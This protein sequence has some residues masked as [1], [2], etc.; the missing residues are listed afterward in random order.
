MLLSHSGSEKDLQEAFKLFNESSA[1]GNPDGYYNKGILLRQGQGVAKDPVAAQVAL[2]AAA[3]LG[4]PS[5][6]IMLAEMLIIGEGGPDDYVRAILLLKLISG[7]TRCAERWRLLLSREM[8]STRFTT[9]MCL[10]F[11]TVSHRNGQNWSRSQRWH[12]VLCRQQ[13]DR[14]H[15]LAHTFGFSGL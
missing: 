14:G 15:P 12:Q 3:D 1:L 9:D 4:H 7:V 11:I 13:R 8:F 6:C 2:K 10:L 5:A